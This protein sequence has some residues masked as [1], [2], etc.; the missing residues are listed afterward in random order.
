MEEGQEG[1][2]DEL[3]TLLPNF[4]SICFVSRNAKWEAG[5][6]TMFVTSSHVSVVHERE[7]ST[8]HAIYTIVYGSPSINLYPV[9]VGTICYLVYVRTYT[10]YMYM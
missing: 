5:R 2:R 9:V 7:E 1:K 6:N 4:V 3:R 8:L 10:M